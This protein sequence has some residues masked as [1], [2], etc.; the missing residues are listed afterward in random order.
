MFLYPRNYKIYRIYKIME[1]EFLS[2]IN[3]I[4]KE[5]A[6]EKYIGIVFLRVVSFF[7]LIGS[8]LIGLFPFVFRFTAHIYITLGLGLVLW[9]RFFLIG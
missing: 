3:K 6:D 1:V 4:F 2:T 5:I 8:N 9:I 7:Y